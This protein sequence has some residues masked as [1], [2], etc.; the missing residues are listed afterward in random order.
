MK[1]TPFVASEPSS[2]AAGLYAGVPALDSSQLRPAGSPSE[3]LPAPRSKRR[4][5]SKPTGNQEPK[6]L[7][8]CAMCKAK[9][10]RCDRSL[11]CS[12][13]VVRSS[14]CTYGVVEPEQKTPP[15]NAFEQDA[16]GQAAQ[17]KVNDCEVSQLFP[18]VKDLAI[19]LSISDEA[20]MDL[21]CQASDELDEK[22]AAEAA[23]PDEGTSVAPMLSAEMDPI[24]EEAKES[25]TAAHTPDTKKRNKDRRSLIDD[26]T[27]PSTTIPRRTRATRQL[28]APLSSPTPT[29]R[30]ILPP[31]LPALDSS[32]QLPS[33]VDYHFPPGYRHRRRSSPG[34]SFEEELG[35]VSDSC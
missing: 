5:R 32:G 35:S 24:K 15:P 26:E 17:V 28:H 31:P 22:K 1:Y 4:K 8:V 2:A 9:K 16:V 34:D 23:Q 11:P 33:P 29:R 13:C 27:A 19:K 20:L 25:T 21:Y 12:N 3:E 14:P 10:T 6:P 30:K 18:R 7:P